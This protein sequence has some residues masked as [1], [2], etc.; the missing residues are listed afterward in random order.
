MI[1]DAKVEASTLI[2]NDLHYG[3]MEIIT[4]DFG[5]YA[6]TDNYITKQKEAIDIVLIDNRNYK[7]GMAGSLMEQFGYTHF[8]FTEYDFELIQSFLNNE[9]NK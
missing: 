9:S 4:H 5:S 3:P 2:L 8:E 6:R 7:R 1:L